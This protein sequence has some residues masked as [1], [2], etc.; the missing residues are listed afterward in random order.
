MITPC[1]TKKADDIAKEIEVVED[2]EAEKVAN[3]FYDVGHNVDDD[4]RVE[5]LTERATNFYIS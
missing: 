3:E 5:G 4:D 1:I 2:T